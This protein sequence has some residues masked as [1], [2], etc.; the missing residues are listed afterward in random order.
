MACCVPTKFSFFHQPV[1]NIYY[2][3]ALREQYGP[4]PKVE[5]LYWDNILNQ[6]V[7]AGVFT[8]IR[9]VGTPL[10]NIIIDHGDSLAKGLV[11]IS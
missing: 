4:Y 10:A 9:L 2:S 6:Y 7:A 8:S 5:V 3:A 11:K 1:S